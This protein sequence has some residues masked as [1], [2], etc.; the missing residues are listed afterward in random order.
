MRVAELA[1]RLKNASDE[2]RFVAEGIA[3]PDAVEP[4]FF[5]GGAAA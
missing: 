3:S 5:G 4:V 1:C 2:C